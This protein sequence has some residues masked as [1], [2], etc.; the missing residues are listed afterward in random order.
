MKTLR[1]SHQSMLCTDLDGTFIGDDDSMYRLLTLIQDK[2]MLLA[3]S[4]G[5]HLPSVLAF[6]EEKGIRRPEAC[7]LLVGTEVYFLSQGEYIRDN[8]WSQI[9][10]QDWEREKI[11]RLLADIRE[12]LQ[13]DEEW[14]TEF[15]ASY[16]L[17]ENQ[18]SVLAEVKRRLDEARLKA[19]VIYSGSQFLDFLPYLSGKAPA[20]KYVADTLNLGAENVVVCGDSGNDID[21]FQAGFKG[22]IVGNAYAELK[23]FKG[24]NAYHATGHYSAG[25]IEGLRHLNL[26]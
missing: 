16:F 14:Q 17:R 1:H 15:K 25:I 11:V 6:V 2:D 21:M 10:S 12:L 3:F 7:L 18:D 20:V 13:Q 24:E 4:T 5:R 23:K 9:I 19:Q 26:I 8:R 22:I